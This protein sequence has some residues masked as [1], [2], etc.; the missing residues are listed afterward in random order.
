MIPLS[1]GNNVC[2]DYRVSRWGD[3]SVFWVQRF[4]RKTFQLKKKCIYSLN[5]YTK[6]LNNVV[7]YWVN[8]YKVNIIN[9][10]KSF[11]SMRCNIFAG[12]M[13]GKFC[14]L[15]TWHLGPFWKWIFANS[16]IKE[17]VGPLPKMQNDS[18]F[19]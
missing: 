16:D 12:L 10:L 18:I 6:D 17:S 1:F 9:I 8:Q 5:W 13:N 15:A 11:Y 19:N 3:F 14:Q 2:M 4:L 7:F